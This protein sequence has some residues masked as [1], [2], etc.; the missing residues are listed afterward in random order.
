[1]VYEQKFKDPLGSTCEKGEY[2]RNF[3]VL[4]IP[5]ISLHTARCSSKLGFQNFTEM[6]IWADL[7]TLD[8][9]WS[10]EFDR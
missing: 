8:L 9:S 2:Y 5:L 7:G 10:G 6:K 3:F 1:M 4:V